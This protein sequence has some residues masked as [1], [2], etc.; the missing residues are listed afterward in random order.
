MGEVLVL[1]G[2][3]HGHGNWVTSIATTPENPNMILSAS[4]VDH[5]EF[6]GYAK[7][8]F[9]DAPS[10][11]LIPVD[12]LPKPKYVGGEV[13]ERADIQ[14][15]QVSMSFESC[16]W[17]SPHLLPMCVFHIMLGG[18]S[19]FSPG[20]PGKG[21]YTRLFREVLN[22][23][24]WVDSAVSYNTVH[25]DTGLLGVYGT[26]LPRDAGQLIDVISS[27]LVEAGNRL[28]TVEETNRSKNQLKAS[29]WMNLESGAI[30]SE[31]I[32]RQLL[33]Y[34]KREDPVSL[35]ARI[36][37]VTPEQVMEAAKIVMKSPLSLVT[38]G[39]VERV[40]SYDELSKRFR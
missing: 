3:L 19:S 36:D 27:T 31:D 21:L 14:L 7:K 39:D 25:A 5:D 11:A 32:G 1:R 17:F 13:R 6:V 10:K 28:P 15:T 16:G 22:K 24:F 35:C 4:G 30:L 33:A 23:Y 12:K 9:G 34:G 38:Y 29:I 2:E 20:G 18:G 26:C 40:P 37:Q 8:Y